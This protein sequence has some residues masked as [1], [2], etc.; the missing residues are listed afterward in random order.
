[1][2]VVFY[3][4]RNPICAAKESSRDGQFRIDNFGAATPTGDLRRQRTVNL[5]SP[6]P[7]AGLNCAKR[8]AASLL[9]AKTSCCSHAQNYLRAALK[10]PRDLLRD[11]ACR[12]HPSAGAD[13][14]SRRLESIPRRSL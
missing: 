5:L 9:E 2:I 10:S 6:S 7:G 11:H 14:H 12:L 13:S 8:R 1:M 4:L 3:L